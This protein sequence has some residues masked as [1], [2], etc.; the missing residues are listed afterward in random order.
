[1]DVPANEVVAKN[2][3]VLTSVEKK[4]CGEVF[5]IAG[6]GYP[7]LSVGS[8]SPCLQYGANKSAVRTGTR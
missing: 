2:S 3:I 6:V 4:E 8:V 1:M 5:A 7:V